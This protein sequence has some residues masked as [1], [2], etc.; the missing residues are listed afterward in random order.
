ML[1]RHASIAL[2]GYRPPVTRNWQAGLS[3]FLKGEAF[4][5]SYGGASGDPWQDAAVA[6]LIRERIQC[7]S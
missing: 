3:A 5:L 6:A 2:A 1:E 4:R 7:R